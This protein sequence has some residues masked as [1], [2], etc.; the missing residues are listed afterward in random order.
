MVSLCRWSP[1]GLLYTADF[2]VHLQVHK[3]CLHSME[4]LK[5]QLL[6]KEMEQGFDMVR[7]E[8]NNSKLSI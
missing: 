4:G 3:Y 1:H 8:K 5:S 7:K 6:R 2:A